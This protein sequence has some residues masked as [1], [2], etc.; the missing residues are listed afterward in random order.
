MQPCL[1]T[2]FLN[3][4]TCICFSVQELCTIHRL[5]ASKMASEW[6][7]FKLSHEVKA[8]DVDCL[9]NFEREVCNLSDS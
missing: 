9:Q 8:I 2:V 6:M 3:T 4:C 5:D 7:A 1:F